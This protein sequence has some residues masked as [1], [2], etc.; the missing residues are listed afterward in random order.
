[1]SAAALG[2]AARPFQAGMAAVTRMRAAATV[3][4]TTDPPLNLIEVPLLSF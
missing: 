2:C 1:M 4:P 3:A